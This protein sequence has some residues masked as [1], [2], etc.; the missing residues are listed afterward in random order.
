MPL[1]ARRV[2]VIEEMHVLTPEIF[3][4][5]IAIHIV[6]DGRVQ[7]DL[8]SELC[9]VERLTRARRADSLMGRPGE[10]GN[11]PGQRKAVQVYHRIVGDAAQYKYACHAAV[12]LTLE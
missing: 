5:H 4:H 9:Q 12:V 10:Y 11:G 7:S 6:A 2:Y 3:A 1:R 8:H